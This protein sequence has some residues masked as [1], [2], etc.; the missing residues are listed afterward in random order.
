MNELINELINEQIDEQMD[1]MGGVVSIFSASQS[2]Y[3]KTKHER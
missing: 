1:K 2:F 3:K